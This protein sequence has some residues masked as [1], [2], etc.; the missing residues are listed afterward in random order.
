MTDQTAAR[1]EI[2]VFG[3]SGFYSLLDDAEEIA[4]D[5]PY[6]PPSARIRV[7]ELNGVR[8]AFNGTTVPKPAFTTTL[9][10]EVPFPVDLDSLVLTGGTIPVR[11][12]NHLGFDPIRPAAAAGSG[13][14]AR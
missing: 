13:P 3:G 2:G 9:Q 14:R 10:S 5:T 4:V 8:V 6:G 7:G 11:V 12:A 1:A